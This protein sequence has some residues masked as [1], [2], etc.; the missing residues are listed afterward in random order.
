ME[1][2]KGTRAGT[3][4]MS[5]GPRG[6]T[7]VAERSS[8]EYTVRNAEFGMRNAELTDCQLSISSSLKPHISSLSHA[9]AISWAA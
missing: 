8:T 2:G 4:A 6:W 9:G 3:A 1:D 7:A 5:G